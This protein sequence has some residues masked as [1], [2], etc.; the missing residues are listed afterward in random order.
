MHKPGT[1]CL[2]F[3]WR[4]PQGKLG[5]KKVW[6][7]NIF[8]NILAKLDH[9]KKILGSLDCLCHYGKNCQ[10]CRGSWVETVR[11]EGRAF[12][13][14]PVSNSLV[15]IWLKNGRWA[16]AASPAYQGGGGHSFTDLL[17]EGRQDQG[18]TWSRPWQWAS[19]NL[20]HSSISTS[21]TPTSSTP[22]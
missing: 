22:G 19:T 18:K 14:P 13:A 2:N 17:R 4:R 15:Q 11:V 7:Q 1:L 6:I 21:P 3:F 20:L 16:E 9:S 8:I 10:N 12:S 5:V